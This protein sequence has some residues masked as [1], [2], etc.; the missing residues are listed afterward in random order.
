MKG[1][2]SYGIQYSKNQSDELIG[3]SDSDWSRDKDDRKSTASYVFMFGNAAFSWSFKKEPVVALSSC[4]AE[5]I[6]ASMTACQ[7]RWINMLLME[8][9]LVKDEKMEL[10]IDSKSA[11]NLAKHPVAHGRS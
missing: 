7:A 2:S 1:T 3:Y 11:I 10:R 8:L 5:Y 9:Q 6:A 4:E